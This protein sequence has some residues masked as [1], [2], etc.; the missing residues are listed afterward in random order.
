MRFHC[1]TIL[2]L[3]GLAVAGCNRNME[4][5]VPGEEPEQPD[6]SRIF[7]AGAERAA[8]AAPAASA[9]GMGGAAGGSADP[10]AGSVEL[11]EELKSRIPPGAVL[12]VIARHGTSGPP[13]AVKRIFAPSFPVGFSIGPE[14]RMSEQFPFAGPL[15]VTARLDAD[16][17]GTTREP[18]D[19]QGRLP[20]TVAPGA[21]GLTLIIDE[22]L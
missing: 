2:A 19:L 13:M 9:R 12:F 15:Q 14:D 18:G 10:I 8:R 1:F 20:D 4:P 3:V 22:V 16:G 5:Y 11:A 17:N 21:S 7:P 6:L